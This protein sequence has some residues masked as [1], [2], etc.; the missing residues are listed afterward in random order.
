[1]KKVRVEEAIGMIIPH[2]MTRIVPGEFKG[3]AFKKGHVIREEDIP[4]LKSMGKEHIYTL[5]IPEGHLHEM[6]GAQR[7]AETIIGEHLILDDPREG[8]VNIRSDSKGILKINVDALMD[9]NSIDQITVATKINN[10]AVDINTLVAGAKITPLTIDKKKLNQVENIV[11]SKGN[12]LNIWP[13]QNLKIGCIITGNEV[14][15]GTIEDKFEEV[16]RRKVREYAGEIID[17]VFVPDDS[18]KICEAVLQLKA[19]G[20]DLIFTSGGMSVDP[21]D[22][23]PEGVQRAGANLISYGSPVFPGAMFMLAYLGDIAILG[24]PAA[25]IFH[26]RTALDHTFPRIL[27]GEKLTAGDIAALGH[28]GLL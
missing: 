19:S 25:A 28:G 18:N 12:I 15:H 6:E 24:I 5:E 10:S 3:A 27:V 7:L 21:D 8:K 17:V 2:D 23:T 14:Y 26:D 4:L 16:F 13:F 11:A 20:V 1:M 22:V 9:I